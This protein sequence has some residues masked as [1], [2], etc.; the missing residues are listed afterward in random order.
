ME[1]IDFAFENILHHDWSPDVFLKEKQ[2][3]ITLGKQ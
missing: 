3:Y 2:S 1:F